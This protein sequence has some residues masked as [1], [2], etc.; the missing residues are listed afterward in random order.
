MSENKRFD[1]LTLFHSML[2]S[3]QLALKEILGSGQAIFV[4]P[5]I[6]NF[7]KINEAVGVKLAQTKSVEETLQDLSNIFK[8][9]GLLRQFDFKK[10]GEQKYLV[11]V[12]GCAWASKV[13]KKLV[14]Q[15]LPCPYALMAMS[16]FQTKTGGKIKFATSEFFENGCKTHIEMV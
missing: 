5:V 12:D 11:H 1:A 14:P 7:A 3:Y 16:I 8:S 9:A 10:L 13:H 2:V 6:T 15:G 4:H